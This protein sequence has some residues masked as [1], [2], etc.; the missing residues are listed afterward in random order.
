[1]SAKL[2][3]VIYETSSFTV[4][5]G[6][7]DDWARVTIPVGIKIET[8]E[9]AGWVGGESYAWRLGGINGREV[10]VQVGMELSDFLAVLSYLKPITFR[11]NLE[12]LPEKQ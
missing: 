5:C 1:M 6:V 12:K 4:P 9:G 11:E 7:F 2:K 10:D 3:R 8:I